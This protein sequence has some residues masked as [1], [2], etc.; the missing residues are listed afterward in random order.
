M[1]TE[2][3][4]RALL[5]ADPTV[6]AEVGARIYPVIAPAD[7]A[8][9]TDKRPRPFIVLTRLATARVAALDGT[10]GWS[11]VRMQV[12]AWAEDATVAR[13]IAAAVRALVDSTST[14]AIPHLRLEQEAELYDR[15]IDLV[16]RSLD[17]S[18]T[19]KE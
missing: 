17:V 7:I 3:A 16:G 14:P 18:I 5:L 11:R 6:A 13:T 2:A 12:V 10:T 1:S 4:L 19:I 15:D 8:T 9:T